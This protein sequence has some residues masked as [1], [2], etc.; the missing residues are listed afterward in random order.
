MRIAPATALPGSFLGALTLLL[1]AGCRLHVERIEVGTPIPVEALRGIRPG[2]DD[3]GDVLR[4]LGPPDR[5][6]YTLGEEILEYRTTLHG[7]RDLRFILPTQW[8]PIYSVIS[9]ARSLLG[10]FVPSS[11]EGGE[12]LPEQGILV[13]AASGLLEAAAG[14]IPLNISTDESLA[15]HTRH[16]GGEKIRVIIDRRQGRVLRAEIRAQPTSPY[17]PE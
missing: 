11:G 13:S 12:P 16:R 10:S 6:H 9:I 15:V 3:L 5:V 1:L 2:V 4:R 14:L 8:I 17:P 7:A